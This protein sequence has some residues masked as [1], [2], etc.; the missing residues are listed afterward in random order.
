MQRVPIASATEP[1]DHLA[2]VGS[3]NRMKFHFC[4]VW[5]E[6]G[7]GIAIEFDNSPA[8]R[9][10]DFLVGLNFDV[11]WHRFNS[12]RGRLVL[13]NLVLILQ[14]KA[15]LQ[16]HRDLREGEEEGERQEHPQLCP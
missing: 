3:C 16:Q 7:N 9:F 14:R 4:R 11:D 2:R 5:F 6:I 1:S 12:R 8:K 13:Q 15:V 10:N